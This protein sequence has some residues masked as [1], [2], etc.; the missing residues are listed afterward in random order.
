M[1]YCLIACLG[2]RAA[3]DETFPTL[4]EYSQQRGPGLAALRAVEKRHGLVLSLAHAYLA[5]LHHPCSVSWN[6]HRYWPYSAYLD[7]MEVGICLS[8]GLQGSRRGRIPAHGGSIV[9]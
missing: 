3:Y 4:Q 2:C 1:Q 5:S 7:P 9:E 8:Q 6:I